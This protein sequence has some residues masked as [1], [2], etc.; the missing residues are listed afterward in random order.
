MAYLGDGAA[1]Q[2]QVYETFNMA[3]LWKLPV[4][5]VIEK[6]GIEKEKPKG[7]IRKILSRSDKELVGQVKEISKQL[8]FSSFDLK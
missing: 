1:N 2:G 6:Q 5:F 4:I 7:K 3:A 8:Y